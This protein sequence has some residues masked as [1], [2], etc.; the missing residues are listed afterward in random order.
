MQLKLKKED[1]NETQLWHYFNEAKSKALNPANYNYLQAKE[2]FVNLYSYCGFPIPPTFMEY[3]SIREAVENFDKWE[4]KVQ[5]I[6]TN[7]NYKFP[8]TSPWGIT[9]YLAVNGDNF[10]LGYKRDNII[11]LTKEEAVHGGENSIT[12]ECNRLI[13]TTLLDKIPKDELEQCDKEIDDA[14]ELNDAFQDLEAK[15]L[16]DEQDAIG[17]VTGDELFIMGN[18]MHMI[19]EVAVCNYLIAEHNIKYNKPYIDV[20]NDMITHS[21]LCFAFGELC[22]ICK[23]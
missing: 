20:I 6:P 8:I 9:Q 3:G 17:M 14:Y 21:G 13:Y 10:H 16:A 12:R 11:W 15:V 22:I 7:W 5:S 23:K 4:E 18:T 1:I 2:S 19:M